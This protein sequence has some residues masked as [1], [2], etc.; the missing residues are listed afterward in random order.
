MGLF[1]KLAE[2]WGRAPGKGKSK[3]MTDDIDVL[4]NELS[5]LFKYMQRVR[6]EI[7]TIHHPVDEEHQITK[8]SDQLDAIV[9]ATEDATD[10]IM[11][12]SESSQD[13]VQK[14]RD[15][16]EG[17]ELSK[18]LDKIDE[19]CMNVF[20]ACSFQD[21]TGQRVAKVLKSIRFV[22]ERISKLVEVWGVQE[23]EK[24]LVDGVEKSEDEKLLNGPQLE[25][26]KERFSQDDI[27]ALFD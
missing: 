20:E 2:R 12:M 7:A 16:A 24:E 27:D 21:I 11:E 1:R 10:T 19:N 26:S 5:G 6:K 18:A 15:G 13:M 22:E 23:I 3:K 4:R 8:M 25:T 17:D 14:I 9:A